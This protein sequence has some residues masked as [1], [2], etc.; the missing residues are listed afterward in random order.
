[1]W[2]G[3]LFFTL[4]SF[5]TLEAFPA[6]KAGM[7]VLALMLAVSY[8]L[9]GRLSSQI[10]RSSAEHDI[11]SEIEDSLSLKM[12]EEALELEQM[13]VDDEKDNDTK[14]EEEQDIAEI[15]PP[16]V[17]PSWT[18]E[19]LVQKAEVAVNEKAETTEEDI[20]ME[21]LHKRL[22]EEDSSIE[23]QKLEEDMSD[24]SIEVVHS[25]YMSEIDE[26]LFDVH[27]E[28]E[29]ENTLQKPLRKKESL[30][31]KVEEIM[32]PASQYNDYF[33]EELDEVWGDDDIIDIKGKRKG[34]E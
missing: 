24:N 2:F 10:F 31:K 32:K 22:R 11:Y 8:L 21:F 28:Q 12:E 25:H 27:P 9:E 33:D 29:E 1:M 26:L 3:S 17:Q 14:T 34:Q 23:R 30:Q 16:P 19:K 7:M 5:V 13:P 18:A 6:W 20:D 15:A 4:F